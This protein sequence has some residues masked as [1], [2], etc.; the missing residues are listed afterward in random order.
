[1]FSNR[2]HDGDRIGRGGDGVKRK[3]HR[4]TGGSFASALLFAVGIALAAPLP[5]SARAATLEQ[6]ARAAIDRYL[7]D[8]LQ[9]EA[10]QRSWQEM[11]FA[12]ELQLPS[13]ARSLRP[14]PQ[15]LQ[16]QTGDGVLQER[17]RFRLRCPVADGGWE[18]D[19]SAQV[20]IL[21]PLLHADTVIER[22]QRLSVADLALQ[23]HDVTR[24]RRGYYTRPDDVIGLVAK[25]RIRPGQLITPSLLDQPPAVQR[26]QP[27]KI[28]ASRDGI[29]ASTMGEALADGQIGDL[30]RV[31]NTSS[32]K[33][34]DAK[35]IAPGVVSSV[36]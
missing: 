22:G 17:Q 32:N 8:A 6:Q 33:V 7:T 14:C 18:L 27:I 4:Q 20:R 3:R 29:Q 35:V 16:L 13:Q 15:P 25:R 5:A 21:L 30:I 34:I 9:R 28:V 31:R 23:P 26:G 2:L 36:F 19:A 12:F 1:M 24:A 11:D 10:A